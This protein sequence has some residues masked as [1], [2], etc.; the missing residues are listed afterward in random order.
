MHINGR[1]FLITGGSSGL[2]FGIRVIAIAPGSFE[3]AVMPR[4]PEKAHKSL[5]A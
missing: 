3:T 5:A 4:L 2:A 1:T